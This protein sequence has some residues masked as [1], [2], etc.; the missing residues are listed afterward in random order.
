MARNMVPASTQTR[1]HNTFTPSGHT[2][3]EWKQILLPWLS[4]DVLYYSAHRL[5]RLDSKLVLELHYDFQV[6]QSITEWRMKSILCSTERLHSCMDCGLPLK[7]EMR[8]MRLLKANQNQYNCGTTKKKK[9]KKKII[10][11]K[12]KAQMV[13]RVGSWCNGSLWICCRHFSCTTQSFD[14]LLI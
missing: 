8:M 10:I 14:P 4:L 7:T 1:S 11:K 6:T 3:C 5:Q 13:H 9:K 12:L 2:Q